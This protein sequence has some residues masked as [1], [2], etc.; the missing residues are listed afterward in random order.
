MFL[1]IFVHLL[2]SSLGLLLH[3]FSFKVDSKQC[4]RVKCCIGDDSS[5]VVTIDAIQKSDGRMWRV[6]FW[7][8]IHLL[9]KWM[10]FLSDVCGHAMLIF[11]SIT[12]WLLCII[13]LITLYYGWIG[14]RWDARR[15]GDDWRLLLSGSAALPQPR[16]W[17]VVRKM[18]SH[19]LQFGEWQWHSYWLQ[20]R[21]VG[22]PWWWCFCGSKRVVKHFAPSLGRFL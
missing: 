20:A 18:I 14:A 13:C 21:E 19:L 9:P 11:R 6:M 2:V 15:V 22:L 16:R 8:V 5:S 17:M 7:Q 1:L 3:Y 10:M 4:R 12:D